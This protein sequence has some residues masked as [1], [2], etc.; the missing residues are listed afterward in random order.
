MNQAN[1]LAVQ[2]LGLCASTAGGLGSIPGWGTKILQAHG[3][4][5]K[6]K[7]KK[8]K[9]FPGGTV[10][11]NPPANVADTGSSPGLGRSHIPQSNSAHEPQL[12]NLRVWSLCSTAREATLVRGR[13]TVM[14]SGPRS[15][16]LEKALA[17]KRRPNTAKN[18]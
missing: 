12:L 3:V 6:I 4:T 14:K 7:K 1:S 15:P 9:G 2:W 17:Q 16:Q 10:V 18:K 13:R 5:K 11:K 8:K